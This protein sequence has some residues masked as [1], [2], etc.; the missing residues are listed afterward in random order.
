MKYSYSLLI[1]NC[2]TLASASSTLAGTVTFAPLNQNVLPGNPVTVSIMATNLG[3]SRIGDYDLTIN[4]AAS[5]LSAPIISIGTLLGGPLNAIQST[6]VGSGLV[7]IAEVSLLNPAAL[8]AL[9][10]ATFTL[11][12]ITFSSA[13]L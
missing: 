6:A 2:L 11:A 5:L 13:H 10:P 7:E 9:Q 1:T 4:F 12:T 3:S 8:T